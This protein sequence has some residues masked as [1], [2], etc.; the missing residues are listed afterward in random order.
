[1]REAIVAEGFGYNRT[2]GKESLSV[3][4]LGRNDPCRCGSGRKYKQCCLANDE[5]AAR[6]ARTEA[7]E[8]A[9]ASTGET[10]RPPGG[11]GRG[12]AQLQPWKRGGANLRGF[13]RFSAPRKV[14]G[15]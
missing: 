8:A 12:Q 10:A 7:G 4:T 1:L 15:S 3:T 14:G 11:H 13:P 2:M 6:K 9:P 5:E